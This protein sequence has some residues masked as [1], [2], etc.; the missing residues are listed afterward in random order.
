M[1]NYT[2]DVFGGVERIDPPRDLRLVLRW[3]GIGPGTGIAR[4]VIPADANDPFEI[5]TI[6][7]F[8]RNVPA[9]LQSIS[10]TYDDT[11]TCWPFDWLSG[12]A[13]PIVISPQAGV[14]IAAPDGHTLAFADRWQQVLLAK[15]GDNAW[16]AS[17]DLASV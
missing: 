11:F 13:L 5:K 4:L 16:Q 9:A 12:P 6:F 17:G 8:T 14:S 15:T 1:G 3:Q 7:L 10:G 2:T